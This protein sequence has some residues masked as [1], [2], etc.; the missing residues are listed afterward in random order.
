M[1]IEAAYSAAKLASELQAAI[2]STIKPPSDTAPSAAEPIIYMA[3]V[4]NT[5]ALAS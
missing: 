1:N 4:R 5:K 3:M 2:D